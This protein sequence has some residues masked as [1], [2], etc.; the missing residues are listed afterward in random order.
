[1][2]KDNVVSLS[3]PMNPNA[4]KRAAEFF[5]AMAI[6]AGAVTTMAP[7]GSVAIAPAGD[8]PA[9]I[10]SP[11]SIVAAVGDDDPRDNDGDDT[12]GQQS[13]ATTDHPN[14]GG[15]VLDERGF[16]W[17]DRIHSGTRAKNKDGTWRQKRNLPDG[18]VERVEAELRATMAA[19]P[20]RS[21]GDV[22]AVTPP[23]IGGHPAPVVDPA[24]FATPPAVVPT[25]AVVVP[26]AAAVFTPPAVLRHPTHAGFVSYDNG[27]TWTQEPVAPVVTV[28]AGTG[29][30][31]TI[32]TPP[33]VAAPAA[34]TFPEM[35]ARITDMAAK[36]KTDNARIAH[37]L[38]KIGIP[39]V[40][41][42]VSRPDLI[43]AFLQ[44]LE[45][46]SGM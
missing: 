1:M 16:P 19:S 32:I 44:Q 4:L 5:N 34:T 11:E 12:A 35:M 42:L 26:P 31:A 27:A 22:H 10:V 6:D 20:V 29:A 9:P 28:P 39:A 24:A 41:N 3:V 18:V 38:E 33:A 45:S 25:D 7:A 17:D 46:L 30:T 43:P 21:I 37:S 15:V 14:P 2:L 8:T 23:G 40:P 13:T 36:G